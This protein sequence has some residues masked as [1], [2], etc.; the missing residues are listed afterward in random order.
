MGNVIGSYTTQVVLWHE[1]IDPKMPGGSVDVATPLSTAD[2]ITYSLSDQ[3]YVMPRVLEI[4]IK[5][6]NNLTNDVVCH[7][8]SLIVTNPD[9]L[10]YTLPNKIATI[11]CLKDIKTNELYLS[12]LKFTKDPAH[13]IQDGERLSLRFE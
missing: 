7:S 1:E 11:Q 12:Y 8:R 13:L 5:K 2:G 10:V 3:L 6:V 4:E 9:K